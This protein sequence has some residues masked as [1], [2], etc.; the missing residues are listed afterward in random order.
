MGWVNYF[1]QVNGEPRSCALWL[2]WEETS[3]KKQ[4]RLPA[5]LPSPLL[6]QPL[7]WCEATYFLL[8]CSPAAAPAPELREGACVWPFKRSL[9]VCVS[10]CSLCCFAQPSVGD[11]SAQHWGVSVGQRPLAPRGT[12]PAEITLPVF[13]CHT[14]GVELAFSRLHPSCQSQG[15]FFFIFLAIGVL[16][17]HLQVDPE[18][19]CSII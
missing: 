8:L 15:G 18:G 2:G 5:L 14:G 19:G 9:S 10:G 6:F 11:S 16:F 12:S 17:A 4:W 7:P 1:S 13:N 3:A